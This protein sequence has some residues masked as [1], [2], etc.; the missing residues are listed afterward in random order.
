MALLL[1]NSDM[2]SVA[3]KISLFEKPSGFSLTFKKK[4]KIWEFVKLQLKKLQV[5]Q[6]KG[7]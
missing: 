7:K 6:L 1:E 2:V 5:Y 4:V 3:L